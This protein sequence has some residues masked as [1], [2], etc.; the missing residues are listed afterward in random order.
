VIAHTQA[1]QRL[2]DETQEVLDFA[3]LVSYAVPYLKHGIKE[4]QEG[5]PPLADTQLMPF[6]P[7]NFERDKIRVGKVKDSARKYKRE[8]AKSIRL[9]GFSYFEVYVREVILEI[10]DFHSTQMLK[11]ELGTSPTVASF[12]E[13]AKAA[14][15]KLRERPKKS[16]RAK[17]QQNQLELA[18]VG[19]AMPL[20]RALILGLDRMKRQATDYK[21]SQIPTMLCELLG[22]DLTEPELNEFTSIRDARNRIA[23]GRPS[24]HDLEIPSAIE[25]NHTLRELARKI[26][27]HV[28]EYWLIADPVSLQHAGT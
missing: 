12:D 15:S 19:F 17:Y 14:H 2:K 16:Q 11:D 20:D 3:I 7:D 27:Q 1:F 4:A 18:K 13:D 22:L 5:E 21:A 28:L 9:V 10:L 23:H 6:K 26:D 25:A 24:D 8:I